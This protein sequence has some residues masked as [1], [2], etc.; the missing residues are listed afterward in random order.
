MFPTRKA[1]E[2]WYLGF[3]WF[4]NVGVGFLS[5]LDI[6]QF[7]GPWNEWQ[8][9]ASGG[10]L[11]LLY[12]LLQLLGSPGVCSTVVPHTYSTR[13]DNPCSWSC[14]SQGWQKVRDE[15]CIR[16]DRGLDPS[17]PSWWQSLCS[18]APYWPVCDG[19]AQLG[20]VCKCPAETPCSCVPPLRD[21]ILVGYLWPRSLGALTSWKWFSF[22]LDLW[23]W[24]LNAW[25]VRCSSC[26]YEQS[27]VPLVST[28]LH[29]NHNC[30][31]VLLCC[32]SQFC[33][34]NSP[35]LS[36]LTWLLSSSGNAA[37][38]YNSDQELMEI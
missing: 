38:V 19:A 31:C 9:D 17:H 24:I 13:G 3:V 37:S 16:R 29:G 11:H 18:Q 20:A 22:P 8:S 32:S 15:S 27:D 25:A 12:G 5:L 4:G 30:T 35:V 1:P 36:E 33:S 10:E 2:Q 26:L 6:R 14:W 23:M 21:L 34:G 28:K 7:C